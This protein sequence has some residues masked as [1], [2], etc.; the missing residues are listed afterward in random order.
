MASVI[1]HVTFERGYIMEE[2]SKTVATHEPLNRSDLIDLY[3]HYWSVLQAELSFC[4]QYLNFYSG[5]L[6]ALLAATLAGL[7]S[8]K[9]GDL[10]GLALLLGPALIFVLAWN[11]YQTVRTFYHR[12]VEAWVTAINLESMLHI[13][14][15]PQPITLGYEPAYISTQKSFIPTMEDDRIKGILEAKEKEGAEQVT[16]ELSESKKGTTLFNA[17]IT[18]LTFAVAAAILAVFIVLTTA[19]P[20]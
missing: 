15:A 11:G 19:L 3:K 5:L 4:H 18:F 14:Y 20:N 2:P 13:R 16:K 9:F 1:L 10:R 7:L 8:I 6:S 12:F 17:K